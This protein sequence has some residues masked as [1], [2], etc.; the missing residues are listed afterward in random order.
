MNRRLHLAVALCAVLALLRPSAVAQDIK[1][2]SPKGAASAFFKAMETGDTKTAKSL[3]IGSDKQLAMLDMLVPVISG[4]KQLENSAVKKWGEDGRKALSQNQS[5][6]GMDFDKELRA[7]TEQVD[8]DNAT[9]TSSRTE[10]RKEPM[11]LKKVGGQWKVD[12]SSLPSDNLDNPQTAKVMKIMSDAAKETASEIDQ[13]K[14]ASADAAKKSM[15][16]KMMPAIMQ[17]QMQQQ[18]QPGGPGAGG[19]GGGAP[20]Q[21]KGGNQQ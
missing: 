17:M 19:P 2:D 20:Q 6:S 21:P 3:A 4:F 14:H 10:Q 15:T 5:G 13:G 7:A 12:M 9:I 1:S 8:G 16:Q 18:Q 11:K